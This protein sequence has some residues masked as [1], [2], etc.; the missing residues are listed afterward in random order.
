[1][2]IFKNKK[3]SNHFRYKPK[4]CN[5]NSRLRSLGKKRSSAFIKTS[6]LTVFVLL[7]FYF[8]FISSFFLINEIKVEGN[9]NISE[10][11]IK[12]IANMEMSKK[13]MGIIPENNYFF[14]QENTIKSVLYNKFPE[15]KSINIKKVNNKIIIINIIE[16]ESKI[17]WCRLDDCYYIDSN[18]T[19]FSNASDQLLTEEKPLKIIEQ[20][21]IEEESGDDN[22]VSELKS[23]SG[24]IAKKDNGF[25]T[26]K[27]KDASGNKDEKEKLTLSSIKIG[28]KVSDEDFIDFTI[29]LNR[30]LASKTNLNIKFFKTKG[31]KTREVIAFTDKN[32][33]L[34]FNTIGDPISQVSYLSE[35]LSSGIEKGK[36]NGLKYIYLESENKIYYRY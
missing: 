28:E 3:R 27:P 2:F 32:V 9:R 17:I 15:I 14:N 18:A 34:Y 36:E 8:F 4:S 30:E 21:T 16:K 5:R 25:E 22:G 35:F 19:A 10:N 29:K 11:D 7:F 20:L 23:N 31:T 24:V 13:F 12:N 33:R 1:M 26:N 6:L